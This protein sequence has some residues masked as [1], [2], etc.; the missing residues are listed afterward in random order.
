MV[1]N[2]AYFFERAKKVHGDGRWIWV[3][4][5][6]G[7]DRRNILLGGD[8]LNPN[9]GLGY[10]WA[11]QLMEYKPGVGIYIFRS[12]RVNANASSSTTIYI[13][14]DGYSDVPEV[15]QV[16]MKAPDSIYVTTSTANTTS[17]AITNTTAEYTG[18]SFKVTAVEYDATNERFEVTIDQS[19]TL[20][21]GDILVEAEGTAKSAS[22][23]V[24]VKNPNIFNEANREMLPTDNSFGFSN[25]K[26]AA[27]GVYDK[28]I[29]IQRTQPLPKY[30]LAKNRSYIDGIFWL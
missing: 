1:T 16:L 10:L 26:Y 23:K 17:G 24:L 14:G 20:S 5:S 25:G 11:G 15:G 4:D 12:F 13:D 30:V 2:L 27:S 6:N 29:W 21:L 19:M 7:E 18:Q 8:I 9:K 28:Q 3:K 22:A